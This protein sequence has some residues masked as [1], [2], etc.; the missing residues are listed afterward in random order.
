MTA[1]YFIYFRNGP[2][3]L[4]NKL[5]DNTYRNF[6]TLSS[7]SVLSLWSKEVRKIKWMIPTLLKPGQHAPICLPTVSSVVLCCRAI[8]KMLLPSFLAIKIKKKKQMKHL[9][10]SKMSI[11]LFVEN[12]I[13]P[14]AT[15]YWQCRNAY[16]KNHRGLMLSRHGFVPRISSDTWHQASERE[17]GQCSGC[18][19]HGHS[20]KFSREVSLLD[21][22]SYWSLL[23]KAERCP[24]AH[25]V[26]CWA[27]Q[28][29]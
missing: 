5:F 14:S 21:S 13:N 27:L 18:L 11:F 22:L 8:S 17:F 6:I 9:M 28:Y 3:L 4:T 20:V 16:I 29:F 7:N 19:K 24:S 1:T 10:L 23:L 2:W 15:A 12:H 25:P 26:T